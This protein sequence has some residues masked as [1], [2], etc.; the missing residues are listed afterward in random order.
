MYFFILEIEQEAKKFCG[1]LGFNCVSI[2]GGHSLTQQ[3]FSMRLGAHVIIATPG[4]LK[5]VLERHMIV[6]NQCTYVVMDEGMNRI[7]M[8]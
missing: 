5:D 4:R 8:E 6:L 7:K 1:P 2:V 3:S